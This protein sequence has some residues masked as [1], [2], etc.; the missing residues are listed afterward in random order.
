MAI[1]KCY[2]ENGPILHVSSVVG[3]QYRQ[4]EPLVHELARNLVP[5]QPWQV[6]APLGVNTD[7]LVTTMCTAIRSPALRARRKSERYSTAKLEED[8]YNGTVEREMN[9]PEE[10]DGEWHDMTRKTVT[11]IRGIRLRSGVHVDRAFSF[12]CEMVLRRGMRALGW[13]RS[14]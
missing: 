4:V 2:Q 8:G 11:V 9:N 5:W 3:A 13:R 7:L 14:A 6:K 1:T 10:E 12:R